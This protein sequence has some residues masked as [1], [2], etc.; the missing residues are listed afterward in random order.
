MNRKL[1]L[2]EGEHMKLNPDCV[3]SVLLEIENLDFNQYAT[4]SSLHVALPDYSEEDL[5]YTCLILGDGGFLNIETVDFPG[6]FLPSVKAVY[7]MTYKGH[8]F[9]EKVRPTKIWAAIKGI[10]EKLGVRTLDG[11]AM[12]GSNIITE[13][14][15]NHLSL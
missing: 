7:S 13:I 14:I 3:R 5:E 15:K 1:C 4:V 8:E 2:N 10:G 6:Q 12:I 11:Y 9:L